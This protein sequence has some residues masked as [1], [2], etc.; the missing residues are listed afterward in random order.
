MTIFVYK[1]IKTDLPSVPTTFLII[2]I[3]EKRC[4]ILFEKGTS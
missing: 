1:H 2:H 4:L 3:N